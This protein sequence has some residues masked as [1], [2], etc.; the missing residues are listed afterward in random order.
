MAAC[1]N[2]AQLKFP[3]R[4]AIAD[5]GD[6]TFPD[7]VE[8][9]LG[10]EVWGLR[11]E[12]PD[13]AGMTINQPSWNMILHF[14]YEV[15]KAAIK[16]MN[17]KGMG[18]DA[19]LKQH[20]ESYRLH[21]LCILTPMAAQPSGRNPKRPIPPPSVATDGYEQI[22]Q[23]DKGKKKTRAERKREAKAKAEGA[24]KGGAKGKGN[25]GRK[26]D[27]Q[28][29]P[30]LIYRKNKGK[31]FKSTGKGPCYDFQNRAGCSRDTC[32]FEHICGKCGGPHPFHGCSF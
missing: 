20:R 12:D 19:A 25:Q 21:H 4:A 5:L 28:G 24:G 8:Y 7:Y 9:L 3:T 27:E 10:E 32:I 11:I 13:R 29:E 23:E 6:R 14:D 31:V 17:F 1:W 16:D 15:R 18:I 26:A 2:M 30:W 22:K